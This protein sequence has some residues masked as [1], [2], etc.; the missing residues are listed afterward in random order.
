MEA[1]AAGWA[2]CRGGGENGTL[3][4]PW[5]FSWVGPEGPCGEICARPR[6]FA[7]EETGLGELGPEP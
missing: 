6:S 3:G 5:L 4:A 2:G 7:R 1:A